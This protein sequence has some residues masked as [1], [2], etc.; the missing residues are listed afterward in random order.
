M[1]TNYKRFFRRFPVILAITLLAI[2]GVGCQSSEKEE[3]SIY[4]LQ[5]NMLAA[6]D[7]LP[8]MLTVNSSASEAADNF[9]YL[10]DIDYEKVDAYFLAYSA[11]GK[12]DE[13]A[14]IRLKEDKD[15]GE[16][17][18]SLEKH[19]QGRV[20]LYKTYDPS[21]VERAEDAMVFTSGRY[22]VLII[23]DQKEDVRSAFLDS[24]G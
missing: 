10:S 3:I 6:D 9:S 19:A 13:I 2:V 24:V 4:D 5:K 8:E 15:V 7:S 18:T 1:N 11:E 22:A 17:K 14:V 23:S 21:Q 20:S 16:A 12:A